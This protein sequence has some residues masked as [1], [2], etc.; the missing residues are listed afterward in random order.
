MDVNT[1]LGVMYFIKKYLPYSV[2]IEYVIHP[3]IF[4]SKTL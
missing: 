3:G 2:W 4:L 1:I